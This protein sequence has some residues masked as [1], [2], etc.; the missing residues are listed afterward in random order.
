MAGAMKDGMR[1]IP[2][3]QERPDQKASQKLEALALCICPPVQQ[4][5]QWPTLF[6]M[7][8]MNKAYNS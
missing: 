6:G 7:I 4:V 8:Q 2:F 3:E 5:N 1:H